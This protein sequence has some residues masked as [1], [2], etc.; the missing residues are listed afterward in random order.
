MAPGKFE[1][2]PL[3]LKPINFSLTEGTSI[4][5]PLDSPPDT[6]RPP[7]PGKGPLS[8]H[9]TPK[10]P[11]FPPTKGSP[12]S[13]E[14]QDSAAGSHLQQT[15]TNDAASGP[16]SPTSPSA[17]RP[18][19][20]RK[21]LG[22]RTLSSSDSLKSERPGSPATIN[23]QAPSLNRRKSGSWFGKKKTFNVGSVPEGKESLT[24]YA[25][26]RAA[27][28]PPAQPVQPPKAKGPPP[29]ALPELKSFG[30]NNDSLSLGGDDMF[31]NIK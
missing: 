7:T 16:L 3:T 27:S 6:P 18:A 4:P 24:P 31:K 8:S 11:G 17:R 23:S 15:R 29:P 28:Q 5:A 22:L 12:Q 30:V 19:S 10:S 20:V 1:W 2:K 21:F 14:S 9:P 13:K 26:G 25:N